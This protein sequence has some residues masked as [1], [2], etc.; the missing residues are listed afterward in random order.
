MMQKIEW[1]RDKKVETK[2]LKVSPPTE[3]QRKKV[4]KK[5]H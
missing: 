3:P 5:I 4:G 2:R 1:K